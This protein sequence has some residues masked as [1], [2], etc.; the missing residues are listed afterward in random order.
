[1]DK[2]ESKAPD[3]LVQRLLVGVVLGVIVIAV[4]LFL[5][6]LQEV[7]GFVR[8]M[9]LQYLALAFLLTFGSYM[10]R[11]MK[12]HLFSRWSGFEI[13]LWANTKIFFIGLMMSITPGKAGELIK[14]YFLQK[15]A[16]VAYAKSIPIIFFDRLT[17][18]LAMMALV[19]I[20]FLAYPFGVAPM[21]I[22]VALIVI[23][24]MIIQRK[25][26]ITKLIDFVTRPSKVHRL[27]GSLHTFYEQT[28]FLMKFRLLSLSFFISVLAWFLECVSLYVLIQAFVD[29]FSLLASISTFSL[30]TLAGALSMIPGGLGAAEGSITGLLMYF[31]IGGT[32]AITIS[33]IIRLVTLWFGVFIGILVY[34]WG[35]VPQR[36]KVI[37]Q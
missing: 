12:W 30:G 18:L 7:M 29:G 20:G 31:G 5:S 37:K 16:D 1:M 2:A 25:P 23:F 33:L 14:A 13:G 28:L 10:L 35:T 27:R 24:F 36:F 19:G 26:L 9:P 6:D 34:L 8:D 3:K 21:I 11:L 15:E 22:L 4:F 32:L 17:D